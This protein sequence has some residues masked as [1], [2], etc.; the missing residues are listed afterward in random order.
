MKT[1]KKILALLLGL[2]LLAGCGAKPASSAAPAAESS[3]ESYHVS[4]TDDLGRQVTFDAP[5][6][7]VAVLIGSFADMWTLAGG[8]MAATVRDAWDDF[9]LELGE[10]TQNLGKYNEISA[11]L[12]FG[13]EPDLVIASANTKNHVELKDTLESAGIP[14]LYCDVNG[15]E[16]YLR[17]LKIFTDITGRQDLY[18]QNG[19]AVQAQVEEAKAAAAAAA[20]EKGA[21]RVLLLRFAASG[22]HAKGSEGTVTG[23]ILRDLSCV[24]IA[25]GSTLLEDLSLEKIIEEDPDRIFLVQ[26]GNDSEGA[27]KTLEEALTGNPAWAGL[28]AVK[29]GRVHLLEKQLY[30]LKPNDRWGVAY[31]NLEK[32]LYGE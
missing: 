16:D 31:E 22:V 21:P 25:D 13:A 26:Q 9:D 3:E 5:P 19:L 1:S 28:T 2:L 15:F 32:I 17:V 6:Q 23:L 8:K 24:N 12:L 27:Q 20:G 30:H 7:R 10:E 14:T 11:E 29:E 4:V 18:E